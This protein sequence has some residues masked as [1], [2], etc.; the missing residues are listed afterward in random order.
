MVLTRDQ[1]LGANDLKTE[2]VE[3]PEWGGTVVVSMMSGAARDAY[4]ASL[5]E[6]RGEQMIPRRDN[7]RAK[8][9]AASVVDENGDLMFTAKDVVALGRKSTAALDRVADAARRLNR[10]SAEDIEELAG[11]S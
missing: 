6:V 5:W 10:V 1:I 11:N 7:Q 4:E 2:E 3:V 9:V 8:L